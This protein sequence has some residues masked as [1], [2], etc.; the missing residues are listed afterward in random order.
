MTIR[1]IYARF[2]VPSNLQ[3]HM[4]RVC[5]I[6]AFIEKH[7]KGAAI[8][9]E[10]TK[11][12]A[13][14]HDVGNIVKFDIDAYPEFLGKEQNNAAHWKQVQQ[15]VISKY[16]SDDHEATRTML[17]EIDVREEFIQTILDK[18]FS[19]SVQAAASKNWPLKLLHY[20]DFRTL[21]QG[22]GTLEDRMTDIRTRMPWYSKRPDIDVLM[23][24]CREI[25]RQVQDNID[26]PVSE[27]GDRTIKLDP[28]FY[29]FTVERL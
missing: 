23:D 13:L 17:R 28:Q 5:G 21:P 7:W 25:E 3:E 20:A 12:L 9:W 15:D 26:L 19:L 6:V 22:I 2:S 11:A 14:L 27:I 10:R 24:A 29:E 8:D 1:E 4:L 16:G 18:Q